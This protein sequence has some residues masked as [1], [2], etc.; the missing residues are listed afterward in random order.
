MALTG[1]WG[2]ET[3]FLASTFLTSCFKG[4]DSTLVLV[5]ILAS[6]F[7]VSCFKG[8]GSTLGLTSAFLVS[9]FLQPF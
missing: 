2:F 5:S 3:D 1:F 8:F 6:T 4:F 9:C 7:L